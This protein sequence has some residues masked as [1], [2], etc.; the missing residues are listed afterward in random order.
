[1]K[2]SMRRTPWSGKRKKKKTRKGRREGCR[3]GWEM[4]KVMNEGKED[5]RKREKIL[6]VRE[7]E[8][9]WKELMNERRK[10]EK[11]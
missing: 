1:M 3:R 6:E 11:G 10:K 9:T 2:R 4:R 8:M 5:G 7:G